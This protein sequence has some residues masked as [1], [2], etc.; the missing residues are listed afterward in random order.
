MLPRLRDRGVDV[1]AVAFHTTGGECR[2]G[3][4]L[5]GY[6]IKVCEVAAA[7]LSP[8][9]GVHLMAAAI[10]AEAPDVCIADHVIPAFV[11]GYWMRRAGIQTVMVIRNDDEWYQDLVDSFVLGDEAFRVGGIVAVSRELEREICP[12]LG[13]DIEF[14]RC[15]SSVPLPPETARY[16]GTRFHAVYLGRMDQE[17]KRIRE[18]VRALVETSQIHPWFSATLYGDGP[19]RGDVE[20]I[21]KDASPHSVSYGGMLQEE[22]IYPTLLASQALVLFSAHE[23]L[24][25][26][27]QEAMA[28]GIPVIA[29]RTRSGL[30]GALIHGANAL[31]IEKDAD[32]AEAVLQIAQSHESWRRM[33]AH[34]RRLA[35][36]EFDIER[37]ADRWKSFLERLASA[38]RAEMPVVPD[39]RETEQVF[40]RYLTSK[41]RLDPYEASLLIV[42]TRVYGRGL[43]AFFRDSRQ[44]WE[45]RSPLLYRALENATIPETE[46]ISIAALLAAEAESA[47]PSQAGS[48]YRLASL[49]ELSGS[50]ERARRLFEALLEDPADPELKPGCFF[51]LGKIAFREGRLADAACL[52]RSCLAASPGHQAAEELL[53]RVAHSKSASDG[54]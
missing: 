53:R 45:S 6:G 4:H 2:I 43:R 7:D 44:D 51:H 35:E 49:L 50:T 32:F 38:R 1:V 47:L 3:R 18:L 29:R 22:E 20:N 5:R 30:E 12:R 13:R 27:V 31:I 41:P 33:S 46:A 54:P 9:E 15:P 42:G 23:G 19:L 25:S 16:E 10:A 26:A 21:L 37:A 48:R 8:V 28:C 11:A 34:A 52:L 24:S 36:E 14:M 40:V 39:L 17:Q